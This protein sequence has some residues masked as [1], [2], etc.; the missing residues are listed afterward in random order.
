MKRKKIS[1]KMVYQNLET[2]FWGI[3]DD[4][5]N[6]YRPLET[7]EQ[8]K[9]EGKKVTVVIQEADESASMFMWGTPVKIISFST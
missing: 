5:G 7:P 6:Q 8:L 1:G 4:E 3:V 2:G 9:K